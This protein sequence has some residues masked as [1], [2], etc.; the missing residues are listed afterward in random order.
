MSY[1][2]EARGRAIVAERAGGRCEAAIENVCIVRPGSMHHRFKPGR[3]W[4]PSNLLHL[5]GDGTTGC[6]GYIEA[7]PK[8]ANQEGLWLRAGE[9]PRTSSV[10]M[11]W[12][13]E[14][15]WWFLDDEGILTHD[16]SE[17]E[18]IQTSLAAPVG[19]MTFYWKST[20]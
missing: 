6:H 5:C 19:A 20:R 3:L 8:W 14:R 13:Y 17:F 16:D 1:F 4:N 7:H 9:D 12:M 2:P 10:H 18:P 11:R 15:S